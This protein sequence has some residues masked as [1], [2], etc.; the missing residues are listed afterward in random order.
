MAENV[1]LSAPELNIT[2]MQGD[3]YTLTFTWKNSAGTAIN[4]T[5]YTAKYQARATPDSSSTIISLT[6]SSGLT[7][8]GAAGTIVLLVSATAMGLLDMGTYSHNLEVTSGGG[9]AT[10]LFR[11]T[12]TILRETV[13]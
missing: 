3:T 1:N 2:V 9:V 5:G 8:G 13:R 11:G 10:T 6:E 12:L 7:L 4:L